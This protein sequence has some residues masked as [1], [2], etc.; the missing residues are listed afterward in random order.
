MRFYKAKIK[1]KKEEKKA[2]K[3][4][5]TALDNTVLKSIERGND[6]SG[7]LA[8]CKPFKNKWGY[9]EFAS[10]KEVTASLRKIEQIGLVERR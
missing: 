2:L 9:N 1:L 4:K 10:T 7:I 6:I 8:K 3:K 5:L